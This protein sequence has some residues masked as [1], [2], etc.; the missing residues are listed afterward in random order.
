MTLYESPPARRRTTRLLAPWRNREPQYDRPD[1]GKTILNADRRRGRRRFA[2]KSGRAHADLARL[3]GSRRPVGDAP[4]LGSAGRDLGRRR[5]RCR[6][7][8]NGTSR[9]RLGDAPLVLGRYRLRRRLGT[10]GF[11]TVWLAHDERLDRQVAVKILPRERVARWALRARGARRRPSRAPGDRHAVRG[12]G[13]RRGRLPGLGAGPRRD[14]RRAAGGRP[15]VRSRRGAHRD[16]PVRRARPRPCPRRDPPR[17]Q[18]VQRA[19]SRAS[20]DSRAAG[21][22]DRLRSG[23]RARRRHADPHRRRHRH[24]GLHGARAGPGPARRRG[25][26]PVLARAGPLRG[27]QRHQSAARRRPGVGAARISRPCGVSVAISRASWAGRSTWPCGRGRANA[28]ASR[29]CARALVASVPRVA[30]EPGVVADPWPTRTLSRRD[31][32]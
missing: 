29:S 22:A 1:G 3:A 19:G 9:R 31:G 25:R 23:A 16:R 20:H 32:R 15:A 27:A 10:G 4:E 18:A 28:G 11:A 17:R 13:R 2:R 26:R 6:G 7:P 14:A 30:D 24:R 5:G 8:A 12:G 21:P